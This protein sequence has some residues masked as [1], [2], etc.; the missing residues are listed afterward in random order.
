VLHNQA[1]ARS[2]GMARIIVFG[3]AAVS[4]VYCPVW[5][6]AYIPE[7]YG[8]GVMRLLGA[9]LWVPLLT[10]EVAMG[11]QAVTIGLSLLV[12]AGIGPYR[13]LAP[14][15][16]IAL[17]ISEGMACGLGMICHARTILILTSYILCWFPAADALTLMRQRNL[18]PARPVMYRAPLIAASLVMSSTYLMIA[19]RRLS[20]GGLAI[21]LD[22]SILCATAARDAELGSAGG[23]G[24]WACETAVIAWAL[25]L[26]FP[27]VTIFELLSPLC[28]FSKR[29]R[30]IW[31]AVMVP[32]H[33]G[34]GLLM[35]I[36][37][38]YNLALTPILVAGFDP[39]RRRDS[40][41][42]EEAQSDDALHE[43]LPR[44]A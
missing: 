11:I 38:P 16:C 24:I 21:Y 8:L 44:A 2:L 37:F 33:I 17:T 7:F 29:F 42:R 30:W 28:V 36:W 19:A 26:S 5:E 43:P 41:G 3:L 25:R 34:T 39:F 27:V 13:R 6:V 4:W 14:L 35:G 12:A 40:P 31:I 22:D 15:A 1:T 20:S 10:P 9:D 32:F 23:L 18:R